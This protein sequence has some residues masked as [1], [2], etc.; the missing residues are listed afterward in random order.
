MIDDI[1]IYE[2]MEDAAERRYFDATAGCPEGH[3]KCDCGRIV[4]LDEWFPVS[5]SPY[6]DGVCGVCADEMMAELK[7]EMSPAMRDR[8]VAIIW[9]VAT[10]VLLSIAIYWSMA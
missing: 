4:P 9:V 3:W 6:C 1:D 2:S 5:E 10:A 8:I 7:G